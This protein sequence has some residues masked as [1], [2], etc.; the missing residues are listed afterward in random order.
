[1]TAVEVIAGAPTVV[2]VAVT[3]TV[4]VAKFVAVSDIV[5]VSL[6]ASVSLAAVT[7]T[8]CGI[9][10]VEELK[11][12]MVD[13]VLMSALPSVRAT[14][15]AIGEVGWLINCTVKV[16]LAPSFI[17][18]AV[19]DSKRSCDVS[20]TCTATSTF[21]KPV[22]LTRIVALSFVASTSFAAEIEKYCGVAKLATVNVKAAPALIVTSVS[23]VERATATAMLLAGAVAKRTAMMTWPPSF[24]ARLIG[25]TI[26][27]CVVV[28]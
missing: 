26:R 27:P 21:G 19:V 24:I 2:S 6:V 28:V 18:S 5:A 10:Q 1:M 3:V 11:F 16:L 22:E 12:S 20:S 25:V 4:R 8:V 23:P 17:V 7:I 9:F 13:V 14:A 15:T